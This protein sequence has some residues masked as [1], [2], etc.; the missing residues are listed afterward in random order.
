MFTVEIGGRLTAITNA[1]DAKARDVF[2][3]EEVQAG[4]DGDDQ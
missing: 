2:E 4:P 3:S 1:G